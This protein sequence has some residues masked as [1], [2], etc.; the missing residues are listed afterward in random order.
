MLR[1]FGKLAQ[2]RFG[3]H[4]SQS[5]HR[6]CICVREF[7]RRDVGMDLGRTYLNKFR[8]KSAVVYGIIRLKVFIA[9]SRK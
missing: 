4:T 6:N 7:A 9:K 3:P 8:T 5:M 1:L 2:H